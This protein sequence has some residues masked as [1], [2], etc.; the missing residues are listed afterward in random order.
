MDVGLHTAALPPF[1]VLSLT[2]KVYFTGKE[3]SYVHL[4]NGAQQWRDGRHQEW[5]HGGAHGWP[6]TCRWPG[7]GASLSSGCGDPG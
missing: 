1:T 3:P 7:E 5:R 4:S 6:G 2:C